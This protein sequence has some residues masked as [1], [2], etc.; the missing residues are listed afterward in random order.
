MKTAQ[1]ASP[2][3]N[4]GAAVAAKMEAGLRY[5]ASLIDG[6]VEA[7]DLLPEPPLDQAEALRFLA[8]EALR[9][10]AVATSAAEARTLADVVF[11]VAESHDDRC[12]R[13]IS[14]RR[15]LAAGDC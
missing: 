12:R 10:Y 2:H 8:L 5:A 15:P 3:T 11:G 1:T 14:E 9:K 4:I 13:L 6:A 7:M